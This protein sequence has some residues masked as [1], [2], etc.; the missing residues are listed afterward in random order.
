M[1]LIAVDAQAIPMVH[2]ENVL[3]LISESGVTRCRI[4]AKVGDVYSNKG[5]DYWHFPEGI[6]VERFDSLFNVEGSLVAD[7]AYYFEKRQLWQAIGNV[8]VKNMEGTV[9]ET[10][11]LFWDMKVPAGVVNAFYTH[12]PVK[13]TKPDGTTTYGQ[14]GFKGEQSLNTW[15]LYG[16]RADLIFE[17]SSD[18]IRQNTISSDT[19][20][21]HP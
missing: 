4:K 3:S 6:Y 2:T 9:F 16:T 7:T 14:D 8:V 15:R 10:S 5:D 18:S 19:V 1:P 21:R 17:E 11:E 12:K 13:I 20:I